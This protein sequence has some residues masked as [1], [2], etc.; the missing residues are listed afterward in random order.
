[1]EAMALESLVASV[2]RLDGFLAITRHPIRVKRGY[3]DLDVVGVRADGAVRVGECKATG[4]PRIIYVESAPVWTTWGDKALANIAR[5]WQQRP[6]WL[7]TQRQVKS[8]GFHLVGNVWFANPTDRFKCETRLTGAMKAE[9]PTALKT[10]AR[11]IVTPS[12]DL[13][14]RAIQSVRKEVVEKA[15][16]KRYGDPL[17]DALRELVRYTH[18]QPVWAGRIGK[19]IRAGVRRDLLLSIFG[20]ENG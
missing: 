13:L 12:I 20:A 6:A 4:Q 16:G 1:M 11:A 18:P 15:W 5:L 7:P 10:K 19:A 3:S 8:V 2:W 17:L 14:F 9:L